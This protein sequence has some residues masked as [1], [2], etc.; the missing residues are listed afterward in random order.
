MT[1]QVVYEIGLRD[2][3]SGGVQSATGHVNALEKSIG[4]V[5]GLLAGIGVGLA[6]FKLAEFAHSAN[7]EWDKMEFAMSQVQAG[8]KS[9][10]GA[11]GLTF[12][13]LK[14][15]A[16]DLSHNLKFTQAEV[17]SMQSILLTFPS[18]A[19]DNFKEAEIAVLNLSTR[20]GTDA[21]SAA[22]QLGKA[23]QSP[24][25]G[26]AALRKAGINV[27]ELKEKF[28]TVTD[29]VER[30]KL[31]IHEFAVEFG[32]SA[33]AAAEADKSFR[34]D[35]TMEE[36]RVA[37]GEFLDQIK[38]EM[39]PA[40]IAVANA[41]KN[42]IV[43]VKEHWETIKN[44]T[45]AL[46]TAW[47]A[48][49]LLSG[50]KIIMT[51]I[52]AVTAA[53]TT[54]VEVFTIAITAALGPIGILAGAI[55]AL[56]FIYKELGDQMDRAEKNTNKALDDSAMA[57]VKFEVQAIKL[58]LTK[59]GVTDAKA[60]RRATEIEIENLQKK[61]QDGVAS[62]KS[63]GDLEHINDRLRAA[64]TLNDDAKNGLVKQPKKTDPTPVKDEKTKVEKTKA[65]GSKSVTINVTI[66]KLGETIINTTNIK[67]GAKQLHDHVVAALT[68]AVNDF[69]VVA[70][71]S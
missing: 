59:Y 68:G 19:K 29:L 2:K 53:A 24:E 48:Y 12:E 67:E 56:V 25:H 61:L 70:Q 49:K 43:W 41:F 21:K 7:E 20:M 52:T 23:L 13:E 45:I 14:K 37:L 34:L 28:K 40:L 54:G 10:E 22:L 55:G 8:L 63:K 27:D 15:G 50:A 57:D 35:K 31:I 66:Q 69:Q 33:A 60:F 3:M 36:N 58:N 18:I 62:N 30:Q 47:A 32:D 5:N 6:A 4:S 71:H 9:T 44:L 65:V 46:G 42:L 26:L 16:E 11:A 38:E 1:E 64:W 39:M 51:S 17:L